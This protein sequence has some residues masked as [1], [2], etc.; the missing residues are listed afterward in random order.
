[1]QSSA[2]K[3]ASVALALGVLSF[4]VVQACRSTPGAPGSTSGAPTS[5]AST[6]APS[7]A[8]AGPSS[9]AAEAGVANPAPSANA[10]VPTFLPASKAG[11]IMPVQQASGSPK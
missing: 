11:P 10:V 1:M 4:L 9:P 3:A 2:F 8:A 5:A 6:P 7:A